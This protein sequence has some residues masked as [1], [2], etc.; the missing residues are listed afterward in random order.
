MSNSGPQTRPS[1]LLQIRDPKNNSKWSEFFDLY[2]P[3]I[4]RW[5]R[6]RMRLSP[7]DTEDVVQQVMT[8]VCE[9]I[10]EFDYDRR[11][12]TFRGW[13]WM[14]T[15]HAAIRW[16]ERTKKSSHALSAAGVELGDEFGDSND[17]TRRRVAST[18]GVP[19]VDEIGDE[20]EDPIFVEEFTNR[21]LECAMERIRPHF[22]ADTWRTFEEI[23]LRSRTPR[24]VAREMAVPVARIYERKSEVMKR[25]EAEVKYLAEDAAWLQPIRSRR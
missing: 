22:Q 21:L 23:W 11:R 20:G 8:I 5:C 9:K 12:G 16:N 10:R 25:L 6:R 24:E 17:G 15:K 4:E 2:R 3:V 18:R 1:L 14:M 19:P 13:L 7:T